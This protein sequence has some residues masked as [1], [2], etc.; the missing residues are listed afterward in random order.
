MIE[1]ARLTLLALG[2]LGLVATAAHA[3]GLRIHDARIPEG[4]PVAPVLAGYLVIENPGNKTV[5]LTGASSDRFTAVEI[6]EMRMK[7]GMMSM[8]RIERLAIPAGGRVELA[9]GGLHLMLIKPVEPVRA[10]QT[11][12]ITLRFDNGQTLSVDMPVQKGETAPTHHHHDH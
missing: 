12:R 4:P 9:P 3:T 5:H 7:D 2:L 8:K 6:H 10:G 11:V 1:R